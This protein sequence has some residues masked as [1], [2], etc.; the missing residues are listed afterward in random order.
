MKLTEETVR[1]LAEVNRKLE[2]DTYII[3]LDRKTEYHNFLAWLNWMS[4]KIETPKN[5][6]G[7]DPLEGD[8]KY[9]GTIWQEWCEVLWTYRTDWADL[10]QIED[11]D[12]EYEFYLLD[13]HFLKE[14]MNQWR[15]EKIQQENGWEDEAAAAAYLALNNSLW[16]Y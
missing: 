5:F 3:F 16:K 1:E 10:G 11:C 9:E 14:T 12:N 4:K 13:E 2:T 15:I 8:V 6:D 7:T